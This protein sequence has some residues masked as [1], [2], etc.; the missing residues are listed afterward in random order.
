[1]RGSSEDLLRRPSGSA[2][3]NRSGRSA[4]VRE[5]RRAAAWSTPRLSSRRA[6]QTADNR[7]AVCRAARVA[8]LEVERPRT[9]RLHRRPQVRLRDLDCSGSRS[10]QV[11]FVQ[12]SSVHSSAAGPTVL[13]SIALSLP[14]DRCRP[15]F[16]D[17]VRHLDRRVEEVDAAAR[18]RNNRIDSFTGILWRLRTSRLSESTVAVSRATSRNRCVVVALR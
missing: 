1:M 5:R 10:D 12:F 17:A 18:R 4:C 7:S 9:S 3:T 2:G 8:E 14:I 11:R 15:R 6:S 16:N 13:I